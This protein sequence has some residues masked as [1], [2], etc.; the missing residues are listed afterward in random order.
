MPDQDH[1]EG[2]PRAPLPAVSRLVRL[3]AHTRREVFTTS[4]A[5]KLHLLYVSFMPPK[6]GLCISHLSTE[7]NPLGARFHR[8]LY[9]SSWK[10]NPTGRSQPKWSLSGSGLSPSSHR[11]LLPPPAHNFIHLTSVDILFNILLFNKYQ[12]SLG[13]LL[14]NG[15]TH[16]SLMVPTLYP[17]VTRN[18]ELGDFSLFP[19]PGRV[20]LICVYACVCVCVC[21]CVCDNL[22][23]I[24]SSL[25]ICIAK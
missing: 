19:L 24:Y 6:H 3:L 17:L 10:F 4:P 16:H 18:Q 23:R 14:S 11:A 21:V 13:I 15:V 12:L 25:S 8:A 20:I 9:A 22:S 7:A 2:R 1:G 5:P